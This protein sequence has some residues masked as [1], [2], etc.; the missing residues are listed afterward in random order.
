MFAAPP[1]VPELDVADLDRSLAVYTE[2]LGFKCHV[3]PAALKADS[4]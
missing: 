2:V 4:R 3:I 1:L